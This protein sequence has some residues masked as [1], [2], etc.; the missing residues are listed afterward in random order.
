MGPH[1]DF[2]NVKLSINLLSI[3]TLSILVLAGVPKL[4]VAW[5]GGASLVL[6]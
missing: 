4:S 1:W 6:D 2:E 5:L 3:Q